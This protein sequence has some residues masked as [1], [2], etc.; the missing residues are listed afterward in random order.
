M[1]RHL[2]FALA[3]AALAGA[4]TWVAG[5]DGPSSTEERLRLLFGELSPN[6]EVQIVTPLFFVERASVERVDAS[7]VQVTQGGTTVPLD[8]IDIRAVS[9]ASNHQW[10][11]ALWG[12]GAGVL[13]GSIT[14]MMVGSFDCMTASGC[15][16]SERRGA[17]RWGSVFGLGGAAAGF[18]IGRSTIYWRPVFP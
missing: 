6:V 3:L 10:Q 13:V 8:L 15:N 16:E 4:P 5:Q 11:G 17:I 14:G 12:F 1:R 18:A 7:S 9:V 2:C